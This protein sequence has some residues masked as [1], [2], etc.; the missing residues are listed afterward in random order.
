MFTSLENVEI[1][2]GKEVNEFNFKNKNN[3]INQLR[4][5]GMGGGLINFV[6]KILDS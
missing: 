3:L 5:A 2:K 4:E 1:A 6:S